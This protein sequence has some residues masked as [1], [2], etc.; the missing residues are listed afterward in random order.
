M[1]SSDVGDDVRQMAGDIVAAFWRR[2][3]HVIEIADKDRG[4]ALNRLAIDS[5]IRAQVEAQSIHVETVVGVVKDLIEIADAGQQLVG[6]PRRE[7]RVQHDVVILDVQGGD[8][9]IVAQIG[10]GGSSARLVPVGAVWL[11]CPT[12]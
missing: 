3:A 6:E 11:P 10:T 4:G 9:E 1:R 7:N 12:K 5:R 2:N 8:F